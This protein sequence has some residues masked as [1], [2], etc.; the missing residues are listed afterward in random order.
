MRN[1]I[2]SLISYLGAPSWFITFAPAD[3][4]HPIALYFADTKETFSP[5]ILTDKQCY[6]LNSKNAVAGARFFHFMVHM[7]IKHVLGVDQDHPGIYGNTSAY[8]GTVEQQGRLT[9][10]LHLLLW[11]SGCFTPQEIRENIMDPNS[12]FQKKMVEYLEAL[13]VGEFLTGEKND[14]SE[15]VK[16]ASAIPSYQDPVRTLPEPPPPPCV[17]PDTPCPN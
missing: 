5:E 1:E 12:D 10:H 6:L 11:I 7:F 14:V 2:W 3:N 17:V 16:E 4:R 13:C 9:L 8:Y 15:K